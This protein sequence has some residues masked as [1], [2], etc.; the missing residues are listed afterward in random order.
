MLET[1]Y[2]TNPWWENKKFKTGVQ[3]PRYL[4]IIKKNLKNNWAILVIG[5][6]RAGK[7]FLLHQT[8]E[9]LLNKKQ[10]RPTRILYLLLDHPKFSN[11]TISDIIK[12]FRIEHELKRN[13]KIFVFCDEVHYSKNWQQE[14]K[15]LYDTEN[16]KF[17]LSGS[18][19]IL[20]GRKASFLTGRFIKIKV[21]PLDFEE[22]ILFKKANVFKSEQ[23]VYQK[24]LLDYLITGG[25]PEYVLEP[26]PQYFIDLIEGV[27]YKDIV[28]L[29]D[30]KNPEV[31]RDL[32]LLLADRSSH[33]TTF[34]KL[35]H[36]LGKDSDT[37][38][39]YITYLKQSFLLDENTR[40]ATS[41]NKRIY[42]AKKFYLNDNGILF[43]SVGKLNQGAAAERTLFKHLENNFKAIHFYYEHKA[44]VD[45]F[46]PRESML[47]ESKFG[48]SM[49]RQKTLHNLIKVA[50]ELKARK[51]FVV[52]KD[53][54]KQEKINN[55]IIEFVPLWKW[56]L[57]YGEK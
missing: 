13:E 18:A 37:I 40:Y 33:Q 36:I 5:S 21:E 15:A 56:L 17:F 53:I 41:R 25:Y 24:L 42:S 29:Y 46:L 49:P 6:R 10:V 4:S 57:Y 43:N 31:L 3:R 23:Y 7:T 20:I 34:S 28:K 12:D 9:Y 11:I 44:E 55:K 16:I 2:I 48:S 38:K 30:I 35:A 50:D 52:T 47:I 19:S 22:Y 26:N 8:I 51:L 54:E 39:A 1:L 27:I 32:F 14:I 45:F